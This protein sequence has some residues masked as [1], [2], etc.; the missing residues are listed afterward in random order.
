MSVTKGVIVT[1]N[2]DLIRAGNVA[3]DLD[4]SFDASDET[5]RTDVP[6]P[7]RVRGHLR[8]PNYHRWNGTAWVLRTDV[9]KGNNHVI[10]GTSPYKISLRGER[11]RHIRV[12]LEENAIINFLDAI[13]GAQ[14]FLLIRQDAT[15]G[16]TL[17]IR[18]DGQN[19]N[20]DYP[21]AVRDPNDRA[22]ILMT[23]FGKRLFQVG[24]TNE[25]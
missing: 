13:E 19:T 22:T 10:T 21:P 25:V 12:R 1:S 23:R 8:F 3:W 4:G 16:R 17:T 2:G 5:F 11:I 18:F 14:V 15:G 6:M 20:V 24:R 9:N 7:P